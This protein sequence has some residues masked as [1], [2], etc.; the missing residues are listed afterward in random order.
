MIKH[1]IAWP[2][3]LIVAA[4]AATG[5]PTIE[6]VAPADSF[7]VAGTPNVQEAKSRLER[8]RLW[9]LWQSEP[10][11]VMW[12]E[13][14]EKGKKHLN[15]LFQELEVGDDDESLPIPLGHVGVAVFP[16]TDEEVAETR[17]GFLV[18]ADFAANADRAGKLV[19]AIIAKARNDDDLEV[20]EEK[21]MGRTVY[22][23]DLTRF[24]AVD[25]EDFDLGE[26]APD[27]L[28]MPDVNEAVNEVAEVHLCR[29]G[30]RYLFASDRQPLVDALEI[31]DGGEPTAYQDHESYQAMRRQIG[32]ADGWAVLRI[33][34][35]LDSMA[36]GDP[37]AAMMGGMV[38]S[39]IGDVTAVGAGVRFDGPA[40]MFEETLC[41]HMPNGKSGLL[42]LLDV[43][44][45]R[46]DVPGFATA[47]SVSFSSFNF[48]FGGVMEFL[49]AASRDNPM[50]QMQIDPFLEQQGATIEK[51]CAALGPRIHG[52][53]R[54]SRPFKLDSQRMLLA[55]RSEKPTQVEEVFAQH[56]PGMGFKQ[57]DFLGNR[58]YSMDVNPFA[59]VEPTPGK[60]GAGAAAEGISVGFGGGYVT[61][62]TTSMVEDALRSGSSGGGGRGRRAG[63]ADDPGY[64]R[65]MKVL[66]EQ[67]VVA[68]GV[69]SIVD[70]LEY[71][72]DLEPLMHEQIIAEARQWDPEMAKEMEAE[73]AKS[74]DTPWAKFDMKHL[75]RFIGPASWAARSTEDGY[76]L[77]GYLLPAQDK[78]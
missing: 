54:L 29:D 12:T 2:I 22:T 43:P 53:M 8:T 34:A 1:L 72:R 47:D 76:V 35:M 56:A 24:Q 63:L 14:V 64:A 7:L 41:L 74:K 62:G 48:N 38:T 28:P 30:S 13:A 49:R 21:V 78:E 16:V 67:G 42:G 25:L 69:A 57:R 37:M 70:Y 17:I 73:M 3:A 75:R 65:A 61:L 50:L 32:D 40:A 71:V 4:P 6:R 46:R 31:A 60:D 44:S 68:W 15:E 77:K 51:I 10:V 39:L 27:M 18:T 5:Q 36:G 33:D 58:I 19:D 23:F 11:K 20:D 45:S 9:A 59:M 66:P 26:M 55:I 52:V